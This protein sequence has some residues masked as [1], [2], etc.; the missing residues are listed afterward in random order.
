MSISYTDAPLTSSAIM[1]Y[2]RTCL[3]NDIQ[4]LKF[5]FDSET[6]LSCAEHCPFTCIEK[7]KPRCSR[8]RRTVHSADLRNYMRL[9]G[10][11]TRKAG[12]F[13]F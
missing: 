4:R 2:S 11:V 9:R 13:N 1:Y 10:S 8:L 3:V 7:L 5:L 6:S 12:P